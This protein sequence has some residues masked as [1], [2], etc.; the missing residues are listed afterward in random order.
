M[1]Q[2]DVPGAV[3]PGRVL[4]D[5]GWLAGRIADTGR[6]W[7]CR[8]AR[9]NATLWWYSASAVLL[10]PT[11]E[12]LLPSGRP[13]D[14]DPSYLKL[15]LRADGYLDGVTGE[16]V[17]TPDRL[18]DRLG[19]TLRPVVTTLATAGDANPRALWAI[20][21]DS[22]AV[23]AARLDVDRATVA[24]ICADAQMPAPRYLPNGSVRRCSCCLLYQVDGEDKCRACPRRPLVDRR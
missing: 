3:L 22:L 10:R 6:R 20:T 15:W 18:G 19:R 23:G 4:Y 5:A 13:A 12:G 8:N 9:I 2:Y 16:G 14:P 21:A 24:R 1:S 11:V 17:V 7:H